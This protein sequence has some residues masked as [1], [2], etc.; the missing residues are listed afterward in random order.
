MVSITVRWKIIRCVFQWN[1]DSSVLK[2]NDTALYPMLLPVPLHA[3]ICHVLLWQ[4]PD[5]PP[6][7]AGTAGQ[8]GVVGQPGVRGERGMLGLPGPAVRIKSFA[9]QYSLSWE[10]KYQKGWGRM[11]WQCSQSNH[12]SHHTDHKCITNPNRNSTR[13]HIINNPSFPW[14]PWKSKQVQRS[15]HN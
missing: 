14:S 8:R 4:G 13:S 11:Y 9:I 7:P 12:S 2:V 1:I 6:G 10:E 3:L 5:G 15:I